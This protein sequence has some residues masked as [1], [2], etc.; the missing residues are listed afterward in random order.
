MKD[1][2]RI[3]HHPNGAKVYTQ[4]VWEIRWSET[5]A[6]G[7]AKPR[8]A[9]KFSKREAEDCQR[10]TLAR[11]RAHG[12]KHASVSGDEQAALIRFRE[13]AAKT[14]D[15]PSLVA[16]V[17]A[18]I[19]THAATTEPLTVS[20][21]IRIRI[22]SIRRNGRS[23][24]TLV[25]SRLRLTKFE[26]TFGPRQIISIT[27]AE[28]EQWLHKLKVGAQTWRNYA[29]VINSIFTTAEKRI[30][31]PH[32]PVRRI[33]K[34]KVKLTEPGILTPSQGRKLLAAADP[35]ILPL[36]VLQ[37]FCGLRRAESGR[38][39]WA[40]I[41]LDV[42]DPFIEVGS[43][44]T[45]TGRRRNPPIPPNAIAWLRACR[46]LPGARLGGFSDYVY[47]SRLR[48][49]AAAAGIKWSENL[50]RHSFGTYRLAV[51][52]SAAQTSEEM[53]N[54]VAVMKSKYQNVT[55]PEDAREWFE[56]YPETEAEAVKVLKLKAS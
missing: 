31:L 43:S 19:A 30:T 9:W 1:P 34:P 26:E 11:L 55:S 15:S 4:Q 7:R 53:G 28:I 37:A 17:E 36:V 52:K 10:Q 12:A 22:E 16:I 3:K 49:A 51:S 14:P 48:A 8:T 13:W 40:D 54:S 6:D 21:A 29:R 32:N 56:I 24:R 46:G 50:L 5:G 42:D 35:L 25:D 2:V 33:D 38:L 20:D 44:I 18:A 39:T 47:D 23:D 27:A 41:R 45:K